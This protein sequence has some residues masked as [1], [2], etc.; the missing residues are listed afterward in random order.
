MSCAPGELNAVSAAA[1]KFT[2]INMALRLV[3]AL[4]AAPTTALVPAAGD[5]V[6]A[7]TAAQFAAHARMYQSLS[8]QIAAVQESVIAALRSASDNSRGPTE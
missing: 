6:S 7:I 3:N 1:H 8:A 5:H 2:D 4:A